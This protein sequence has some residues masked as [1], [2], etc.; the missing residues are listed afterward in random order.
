MP[1]GDFKGIGNECGKTLN[2][3]QL[4]RVRQLR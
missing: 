4:R 3:R 1:M 2:R